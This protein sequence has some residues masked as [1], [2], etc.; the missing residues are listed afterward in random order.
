MQDNSKLSVLVIDPSPGMRGSLQNM[1]GL[2]NINKIEYAVSSGT[3]IRQLMK[4]SYDVI[5]C[6]YDLGS[7][8]DDGQDGQ[9]LLEDLRHHRLIGL[10]TIFIMI[11]SE[12]VYSKVVSAAELTPTDYI[13][14]PFTVDML[15][16]RIARALERRAAFLPTYLQISQGDLRAAIRSCSTAEAKGGRYTVDFMRLRA[17]LHMNLGELQQAESLYNAI[18]SLKP[19]GWA[20]LGLARSL[21]G[22]GRY[23]E[24]TEMLTTL[25]AANPRFMAAYDLLSQ[26]Y[27]A[28]GRNGDAK[29]VLE[30]AVA[31][32]PHMVRRLRTLGNV[33]MNAG[34]VDTAEKSFRQVVARARYSEFR[35][36]EDYVNLVRAN[37]RKGDPAGAGATIR[38]M[39]K[40]M[41][42]NPNVEA[43]LAVSNAMVH[44]AARDKDAA[45]A[46]LTAA[47]EALKASNGLSAQLKLSLARS[48]MQHNLDNQ[49][50]QV[51]LDALADPASG[52]SVSEATGVFLRAGRPD[53]AENMSSKMKRQVAQLLNVAAEKTG[54]GD[55]KGAVHTLS[56][57]MRM[58][59]GNL[60]VMVELV[61]GILRQMTEL[62]W[63][64][65][66]AEVCTQQLANIRKVDPSNA[67]VADLSDEFNAAKRRYGIAG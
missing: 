32:S 38:D 35:D 58:A 53:L 51:M 23:E 56:E 29:R 40:T 63:D 30:E 19:L 57:A 4:K 59:P 49:A 47:V 36:P 25:I 22:Q 48:C 5:L 21:V 28:A 55:L 9:Q 34:D 16:G 7:G 6:E 67:H 31:V 61:R 43:C 13:L 65:P 11:T 39:E 45:V 52:V 64:H 8:Q 2:L 37:I 62:G 1:L 41:R 20:Q 33:A 26:C 18:L 24:A 46:S 50:T 27:E 10:L 14:K 44:D 54:M 17:E 3:A 15:S 12:G 66:L 42:G 60:Q